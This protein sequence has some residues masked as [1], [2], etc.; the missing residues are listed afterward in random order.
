MYGWQ[1]GKV[2]DTAGINIQERRDCSGEVLEQEKWQE[3]DQAKWKETSYNPGNQG[4]HDGCWREVYSSGR[5]H[6]RHKIGSYG[7][8]KRLV[9]RWRIVVIRP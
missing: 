3:E 2:L 7:D 4:L 6:N 1:P 9:L 5:L 8:W